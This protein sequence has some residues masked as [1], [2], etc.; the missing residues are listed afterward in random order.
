MS[1]K[2]QSWPCALECGNPVSELGAYVK[3]AQNKYAHL[4]CMEGR[5]RGAALE[6][7]QEEIDKLRVEL[8]VTKRNAASPQVAPSTQ[9]R[10]ETPTIKQSEWDAVAEKFID[11]WIANKGPLVPKQALKNYL[12]SLYMEFRDV[13]LIVPVVENKEKQ[14]P[15]AV[16]EPEVRSKALTMAQQIHAYEKNLSA[17][18]VAKVKAQADDGGDL[19]GICKVKG[20]TIGPMVRG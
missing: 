10:L 14:M 7:S 5:I 19:C 12:W 3:I 4:S 8:E 11:R 17:A 20:C 16:A 9:E 13:G 1:P 6:T 2:T 18:Q 15:S